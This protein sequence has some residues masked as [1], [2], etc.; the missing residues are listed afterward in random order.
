MTYFRKTSHFS[1]TLF[2]KNNSFNS[3]LDGHWPQ[4]ALSS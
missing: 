4:K 2:K 1:R 3:I